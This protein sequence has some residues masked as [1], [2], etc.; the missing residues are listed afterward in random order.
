MALSM[1]RYVDITSS[2][3]GA[4]AVTYKETIGRFFTTNRLAPMGEVLEFTSYKNVYSY[5]GEDAYET[6]MAYKYFSF[7][8][9][10]QTYPKRLSF[11]RYTTTATGAEIISGIN[12]FSVDSFTT[13]TDSTITLNYVDPILGLQTGTTA[14]MDFSSSTTLADVATILQSAVRSIQVGTLT[15]FDDATVTYVDNLTTALNGTRFILQMPSGFG[16]FELPLS[17]DNL[18]SYLGWTTATEVIIGDGNSGSNSISQEVERVMDIS[19]NCYTF[20]FLE[21]LTIDEITSVAQWNTFANSQYMYCVWA[22]DLNTLYDSYQPALENDD[23]VWIQ[24][25]NINGSQFYQPM[26]IGAC[27]DYTKPS[28]STNFMYQSF[29]IDKPVVYD[30]SVADKL[31]TYNINYYGAVQQA[32]V[33]DSF[34]QRGKCQGQF[35]DATIG[36]NSIWLK[37]A[38]EVDIFNLFRGKNAVPANNDGIGM[39]QNALANVWARGISNGVILV[40]KD[41]SDSEKAFIE[42]LTDDENAWLEVYNNGYWFSSYIETSTDPT[43]LGE[44]V[45][46][47]TLIYAGADQIRKVVGSHI[48]VT[49]AQ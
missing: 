11:A 47:Y 24:Y 26:A 40:Q 43:T 35:A 32:G 18:L 1:S 31:D 48:A 15:P 3:G 28:S 45:F 17:S 10:K 7:I 22:K 6:Q 20:A 9:K 29:S 19:N 12:S 13:L 33:L 5:F 21:D 14:E 8:S 27:I 46:N 4:S 41:L 23:L 2:A 49:T 42:N 38:V 39:I 25:D 16:Y 34:L 36:F 44:K 37:N 30:N